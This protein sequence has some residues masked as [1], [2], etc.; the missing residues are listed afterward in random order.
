MDKIYSIIILALL[1]GFIVFKEIGRQNKS[2]LIFRIAASVLA[3]LSLFFIALPIRYDRK[4]STGNGN[5]AVLLTEGYHKDSLA[6]WKNVSLFSTD[7]EITEKDKKV[8]YIPDIAYFLSSN[9][10]YQT[11][12]ILG[13]GLESDEL[14][15]LKTKN[16]IF[17]PSAL[18][19]GIRSISWPGKIRSGEQ[20]LVQGRYNN[21]TGTEVK[22]ILQGL[23]TNL[24]STIIGK[25]TLDIFELSCIP[26]HLDKAVYSLIALADKDTISRE[27][28]PVLVKERESLRILIL[29]SSPDFENKFLKNWLSGQE[30]SV[31]VRTTISTNKYSTEF[32]NSSKNDLKRINTSLLNNFDILIGDMSEL[33][34]L[35]STEN[36]A[37]QNQVNNGMGLIIKADAAEPGNGFYRK[38]FTIRENKKLIPKTLKLSWE[39]YSATKT[40]LQGSNSIEILAQAGTQSLVK[41]ESGDILTNSKLSGKGRILLTVI[42][43][44]YTWMLGNNVE[45][46]SSFWTY[47]LEKAARKKEYSESFAI[48]SLPVI[49]KKTGIEFQRETGTIPDIQ[50]GE[51]GIAFKQ[52]PVLRFQQAGSFWPAQPGWQSLQSESTDTNWFYV[53]DEKSWKGVKV[54]EKLKNT[55]I[56]VE[57]SEENITTEKGAIQVYED[58]ISPIW[59][60][61]LFLLCCTYLWLE[62]KLS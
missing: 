28:L 9:P 17:H 21:T 43:D 49:N 3:I 4:V 42:N 26:K 29:A 57:R 30:Y 34:R 45:D 50:I 38:A 25:E 41:N 36:Q 61:I 35:S 24:D 60:Y 1:L 33:S 52:H 8:N 31:S 46:Y 54:S 32:L 59:F 58:T 22:L 44:S 51:E 7:R 15:S 16:L 40:V 5:T 19:D 55:Q 12:H 6:V 2:N 27:E 37:V 14:K 56:S 10:D 13:Y 48:N 11:L 47:I 53:F 20:L 62:V 39:G 18:A 23:G